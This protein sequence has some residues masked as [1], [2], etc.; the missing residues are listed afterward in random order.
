MGIW[1][2]EAGLL[3]RG[4]SAGAVAVKK[5]TSHPEAFREIRWRDLIKRVANG[6][7]R[8]LSIHVKRG[9]NIRFSLIL[10]M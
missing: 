7:E 6:P 4:S 1:H 5:G 2:E 10:D 3:R 9:N 8:I